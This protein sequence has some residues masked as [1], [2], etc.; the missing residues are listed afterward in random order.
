MRDCWDELR[1]VLPE[2]SGRL[3]LEAL[4]NVAQRRES[5]SVALVVHSSDGRVMAADVRPAKML[6][7]L[8]VS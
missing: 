8:V 7:A 2:P 6:R 4:R 3:L 1:E 5:S